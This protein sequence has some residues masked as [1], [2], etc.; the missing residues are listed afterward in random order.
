MRR[1]MWGAA[2][3]AAGLVL[4]AGPATS[5]TDQVEGLPGG[6]TVVGGS[7]TPGDVSPPPRVELV[8]A[9][10]DDPL[11]PLALGVLAEGS[12]W[13]GVSHDVPS[14]QALSE[15]R[16]GMDGL[17]FVQPEYQI[18]TADYVL[19][20]DAVPMPD[21]GFTGSSPWETPDALSLTYSVEDLDGQHVGD[22]SIADFVAAH[23][24][25][26]AALAVVADKCSSE[27][28]EMV[29]GV[30]LDDYRWAAD[31]VS[32][33][34]DFDEI[35]RP[36]TCSLVATPAPVVRGTSTGLTYSLTYDG[37]PVVGRQ[38]SIVAENDLGDEETHKVVTDAAGT[39]TWTD[40]PT[41][42]TD[43]QVYAATSLLT[44]CLATTRVGVH[45][46][47]PLALN[48]TTVG[49][50]GTM[51]A[52]GTV[53]PSKYPEKATLWR[54]L[55]DGSRTRLDRTPLTIKGAYRL[56]ATASQ[57]GTWKLVVTVPAAEG[58]LAGTSPTK[59]VSVQ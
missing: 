56:T 28:P 10:A 13:A 41:F 4:P 36:V 11:G 7:C 52:T 18:R 32:H 30:V 42:N 8:G 49:K 9:P 39:A 55:A 40:S 15:W 16:T 48:R 27:V 50:G 38:L 23:G 5:A 2:L 53:A 37:Q 47:V 20:A 44:H 17:A 43:Y 58:N 54:V 51:I 6:W 12:S 21:G 24:D 33:S 46:K 45:T 19:T 34:L 26:P 3:L 29:G 14:L 22:Q 1:H 35:I 57:R 31:G 59:K 25:S